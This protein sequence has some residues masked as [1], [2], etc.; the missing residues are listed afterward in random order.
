[1]MDYNPSEDCAAALRDAAFERYL[2]KLT[3]EEQKEAIH[4]RYLEMAIYG[5][6]DGT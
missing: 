2:E 6:D 3:P 1:M 5:A 4:E